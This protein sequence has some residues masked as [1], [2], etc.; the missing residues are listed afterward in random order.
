[1]ERNLVL[2]AELPQPVYFA[3]LGL[4]FVVGLVLV[5]MVGT[6][7]K[8]WIRALV[9]GARVSYTELLALWMRNVPVGLIVDSRITAVKSGLDIAI[10]QLNAHYQAGGNVEMVERALIMARQAGDRKSVG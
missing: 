6:F 4:L 5:L 8:I 9:S 1:M 7:F 10:D 3:F 2:F